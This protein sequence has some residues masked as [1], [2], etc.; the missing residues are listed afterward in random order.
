MLTAV[1]LVLLRNKNGAKLFVSSSTS[2]SKTP[3]QELNDIQNELYQ[4]KRESG[5]A[6]LNTI[7]T[8]DLFVQADG[9]SIDHKARERYIKS[10][11]DSGFGQSSEFDAISEANIKEAIATVLADY[12]RQNQE[13]RQQEIQE[14]AER[15]Q[16][17]MP[18]ESG[19]KDNQHYS[20]MRSPE[21]MAKAI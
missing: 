20:Y 17:Q 3:Q 11:L 15:L 19:M 7:V 1:G 10:L 13:Q 5:R 2:T 21:R 8:P 16:A 14:H 18:E 12:D 4:L 9:K 6:R